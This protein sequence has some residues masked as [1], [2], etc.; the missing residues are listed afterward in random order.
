MVIWITFLKYCNVV[1]DWCNNS[2]TI[3]IIII[4]VV[5]VVVV[6]VLVVLVVV[7]G[8]LV[9]CTWKKICTLQ[10]WDRKFLG[11]HYLWWITMV[12]VSF[13]FPFFFLG[14]F[15]NE[16]Q[17]SLFTSKEYSH[18]KQFHHT[19]LYNSR[20]KQHAISPHEP[21]YPM[22]IRLQIFFCPTPPS[23]VMQQF[24]KRHA[25][26]GV[27]ARAGVE[28]HRWDLEDICQRVWWHDPI[29]VGDPPTTASSLSSP[30]PAVP[31]QS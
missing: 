5:V 6:V 26:L 23:G 30:S 25:V 15:S 22:M 3:I 8:L 21:H 19:T 18:H 31:L 14:Y 16:D 10:I 7:I 2:P 29:H 4:I 11:G 20:K 17:A 1:Y 24:S 9:W 13:L 12:L 27:G 28:L